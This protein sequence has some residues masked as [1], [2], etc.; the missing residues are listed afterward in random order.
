MWAAIVLVAITALAAYVVT[1]RNARARFLMIL[2]D[3]IPERAELM[4]YA[5][6]KGRAGYADHC[7]ACHGAELKGDRSR[8]IPDLTD[9]DWLYGSG[10]IVEL[11][12]IVLYGIRSGHPK[13]WNLADM[14]GYARPV[15]YKRYKV[16]TLTAREV[17]DLAAMILALRD[18]GQDPA[19]VARGAQLFHGENRGGC[20]DCH[21]HDAR[22][23]SAI[24][25][26]NL[27]DPI[28]LYGDGSRRSIE[29][30]IERGRAGACPAWVGR[31]PLETARS[32][33]VY[34]HS[35]APQGAGNPN[36]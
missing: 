26:P 31:L 32:I 3:S 22:G 30:S 35:K 4:T 17:K 16:E 24:G 21:S 19:A 25:A 11:E 23:D 36:G 12:R 18:S 7:Q 27:A 2:P 9:K 10:R 33:A 5:M 14:P 8:G 13:G 34:V 20:F 15:P 1:S 29:L 28:W 6:R